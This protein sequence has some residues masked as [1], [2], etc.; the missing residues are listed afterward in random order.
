MEFDSQESNPTNGNDICNRVFSTWTRRQNKEF[1]DFLAIQDPVNSVTSRN[2][3]PNWKVKPRQ[4]HAIM[5]IKV[6]IVLW[7]GLAIDE[8]TI[9]CKGRH[10]DILRITYKKRGMA[11]IVIHCVQMATRSYFTSATSWI[12]SDL[13]INEC[14]HYTQDEWHFWI[15]WVHLP[16]LLVRTIFIIVRNL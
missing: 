6:A 1:K 12:Q 4:K 13:L 7:K 16:T 2:T 11:S 9:Y 15:R 10:L 3:H 5:V 14:P 8:E